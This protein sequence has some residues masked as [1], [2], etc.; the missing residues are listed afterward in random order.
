MTDQKQN[1]AISHGEEWLNE[2]ADAQP[3]ATL[4]RRGRAVVMELLEALRPKLQPNAPSISATNVE[5]LDVH[6]NLIFEGRSDQQGWHAGMFHAIE[7]AKRMGAENFEIVTK[8]EN[9][10]AFPSWLRRRLRCTKLVLCWPTFNAWTSHCV[11]RQDLRS[12]IQV[13]NNV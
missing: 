4:L 8:S 10:R 2:T 13:R 5:G 12:S 11:H 1:L 7:T 9:Y 3:R 6:R